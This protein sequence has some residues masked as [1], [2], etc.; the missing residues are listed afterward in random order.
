M[1][2][3]LIADDHAGLRDVLVETIAALGHDVKGVASGDLAAQALEGGEY[4]LLVTDLRMPG[5]DGL[6]LLG[7]VRQ[8][9]LPV[10]A[11]VMTAHGSVETAVKAMQIGAIDYVEKPFPLSAMEAKVKKAGEHAKHHGIRDVTP[12]LIAKVKA[13]IRNG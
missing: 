9:Q 6:A 5:M 13:N 11:I 4:E 7:H 2:R 1:A 10:Q 12:E 8:K 3:I